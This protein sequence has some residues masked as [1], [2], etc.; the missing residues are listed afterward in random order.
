MQAGMTGVNADVLKWARE[1][2]GYSLQAVADK[3]D[4]PLDLIKLW[5]AGEEYPTYTDLEKLAYKI[6]KRPLAVFFFPEPPDEPNIKQS[7]RTLPNFE[8]ENLTPETLFI[9]RKAKAM[10]MLL[11]L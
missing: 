1:T 9:I 5:E 3:L 11:S 4:K 7:F 8:I 10:Q 2:S 6:Y